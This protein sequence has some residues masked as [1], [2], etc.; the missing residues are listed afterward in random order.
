M[1]LLLDIGSPR[2]YVVTVGNRPAPPMDGESLCDW[3]AEQVRSFTDRSLDGRPVV[4]EDTTNFMAID[5]DHVVNLQGEFFLVRC[6][7]HEL[8]FGLEDQPKFWVKR[9]MSLHTGR[10]HILKL[11]IREEFKTRIGSVEIR[12]YRSEEKEG[13]VLEYVRGDGRFMQGRTVRDV[14]GNLVRVIDFIRGP[15]LINYLHAI[16]LSHEEYFHERLPGIMP[17]VI[18]CLRAIQYLHDGGLCHGDIRNDHILIEEETGSYRWIDFDLT[19]DFSDYDVASIG[20]ILHMV[21]GKQLTAMRQLIAA[22][23]G[24]ADCLSHED[25]S[26]FFPHRLM[27]FRKVYP[28]IPKKLNDV[29]MRFSIGTEVFYDSVGQVVADIEDSCVSMGWPCAV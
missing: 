7:E 23:P 9:A 22:E 1:S 6:N 21:V 11:V 8:R 14:R 18:S 4:F 13:R 15:S 28:Y 29:L 25:G 3:I 20:N 12:C 19:Q 10:L 17:H 24:L 2:S 5:R 16:P 27:N 26:S